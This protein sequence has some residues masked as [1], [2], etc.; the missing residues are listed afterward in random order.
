[1]KGTKIP[2]LDGIC[3]PGVE[4]VGDDMGPTKCGAGG[5]CDM[6]DGGVS[7]TRNAAECTPL[8]YFDGEGGRGISPCALVNGC[9]VNGLNDANGD[10]D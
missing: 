7:G 4:G 5:G 6:E 9:I 10:S 8:G 2:R 3:V 1:M